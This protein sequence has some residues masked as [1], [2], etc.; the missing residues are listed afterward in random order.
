MKSAIL[1]RCFSIASVLVVALSLAACETTPAKPA[2]WASATPPAAAGR[3]TIR[4]KAGLDQPWKDPQ[5][6]V[7]AADANFEGGNSVDRPDLEITGTNMPDLYRSERYSMDYYTFK[8]PNG[9]YL[10]KLHF[11]EDY[12]GIG[13]PEERL[14]TYAVK[15]GAP[16]GGKVIKEVK[17]FSPWKAA[18][19]HFKAYVDPVPVNVT[20]GQLT[21]TFTPEVE[22]PQINGIEIIPQ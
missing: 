17:S 14:F 18:G 21:I 5:G 8:V 1:S 9:K 20:S 16:T 19:N 3:P 2:A 13:S 12:D 4:I 6:N 10:L 11:S 7:W 22:N 15:D